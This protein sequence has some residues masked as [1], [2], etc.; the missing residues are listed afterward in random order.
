MKPIDADFVPKAGKSFSI[1]Y[2]WME[3]ELDT[4]TGF[5]LIAMDVYED[6]YCVEC[7]KCKTRY[8]IDEDEGLND[9]LW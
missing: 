7:P 2:E 1:I 6:S 3:H 5:P 9:P 8:E 4:D